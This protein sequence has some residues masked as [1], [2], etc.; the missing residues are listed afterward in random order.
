MMQLY[1]QFA[2]TLDPDG[3]RN[4]NKYVFFPMFLRDPSMVDIMLPKTIDEM[5]AEDENE[6]L[7]ENK[8]PDVAETDDHTT[9][10]YVHK[11]VMPKTNATWFHIAWHE[12]LLAQ[13]KQMAGASTKSEPPK[14]SVSLKGD[15]SPQVANQMVGGQ[16]GME[17]QPEQPPSALG[18]AG[19]VGA[20]KK[21]PVAM[22]SPLKTELR[23]NT[24]QR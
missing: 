3:M 22:A 6:M 2:A 23:S 11:Q 13:Q 15:I 24:K 7:K 5:K 16:P 21:S 9:H 4:F 17:A 14:V 19:K 10:L 1:P 18:G 20:E 8:M 12:E